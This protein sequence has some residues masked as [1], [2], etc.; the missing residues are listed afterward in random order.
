[1]KPEVL[2][3]RVRTILACDARAELAKVQVPIL[4]LQ[5][6]RDRLV[7]PFCPEN[8]RHIEPQTEVVRIAGP[9]LILQRQPEQSAAAIRAFMERIR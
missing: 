9:H 3:Q 6:T 7:G 5:A 4:Y 8:I 1:V 2:K